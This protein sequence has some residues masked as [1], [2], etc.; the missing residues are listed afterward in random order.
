MAFKKIN[1]SGQ[2]IYE[3]FILAALV[4]MFVLFFSST[5]LFQDLKVACDDAFRQAVRDILQ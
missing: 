4:M 3:Y 2:S 5:K 1:K